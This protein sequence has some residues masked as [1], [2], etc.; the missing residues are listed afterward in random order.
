M[1]IDRNKVYEKYHAHCAYCGEVIKMKDM[2]VDHI[3]PKYSWESCIKN[4][5]RIPDFLKHLTISDYNHIDNLNPACRVCN[6]WKSAYDLEL[7]RSE[8]FEQVKR[9]NDYSSNFRMAKRYNQIQETPKPIIFYFESLKDK[10]IKLI[11]PPR[12]W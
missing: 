9:L 2:Q 6:K 7:F 8:I 11:T 5:F 1:K 12:N 10:F 3:I 4:Q